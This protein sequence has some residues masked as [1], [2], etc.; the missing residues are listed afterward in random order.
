LIIII[1]IIQGDTIWLSE[2]PDVP[3]SVGWD[4]AK[5]RIA[6]WSVFE[7]TNALSNGISPKLVVINTHLDHIGREARAKSSVILSTLA[8]NL[9]QRFVDA[10]V[11]VCGDYN[12]VK[13]DNPVY[14]TLTSGP[15]ALKDA[16]DH[17]QTR[18]SGGARSTIHKFRG[19]A[20][21]E[22]RGDGTVELCVAADLDKDDQ[23]H[24]D[25]ILF[26]ESDILRRRDERIL[27]GDAIGGG[28]DNGSRGGGTRICISKAQVVTDRVAGTSRYP[29]D[30]Y[31][32]SA[33]LFLSSST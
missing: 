15:Y 4:A 30:H 9:T 33:E 25:W 17:A 19:L 27:T 12:S 14:S 16:W 8:N 18:D 11:V 5:A 23:D 26:R 24:I 1:I 20:F 2:S 31:P 32:V 3:K 6:T 28:D 7:T 21:D 13:M 29:S 10:S 22:C